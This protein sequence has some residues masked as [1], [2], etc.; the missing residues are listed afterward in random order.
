MSSVL[1]KKNIDLSQFDPVTLARIAEMLSIE[2]R[3]SRELASR[4]LHAF[5]QWGKHADDCKLFSQQILN[6]LFLL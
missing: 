2:A 1:L 6:Y 5:E 3:G 4:N